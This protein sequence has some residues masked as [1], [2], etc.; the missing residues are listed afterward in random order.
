V[1]QEREANARFS[2][3]HTRGFE[4]RATPLGALHFIRKFL[5]CFKRLRDEKRSESGYL[6]HRYL[7]T[8]SYII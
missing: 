7:T 8:P 2:W 4:E 5:G 6:G 1:L 3:L